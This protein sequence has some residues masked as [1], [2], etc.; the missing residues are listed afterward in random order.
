MKKIY[1]LLLAMSFL[2]FSC[3]DKVEG[4]DPGNSTTSDVELRIMQTASGTRAD[5]VPYPSAA[6][7]ED[8]KRI[9]TLDLIAFD[10]STKEFLYTRPAYPT[11]GNTYRA[12]LPSAY[13]I[14]D[15]ALLANCPASYITNLLASSQWAGSAKKWGDF[16]ELLID[17]D[18]QRLVN[19]DNFQ[20]LPMSRD[21]LGA[22]RLLTTGVADWGT[23]QL[24]RSVASVDV[25]MEKN[26]ATSKLELTKVHAYY[27]ASKGYI[28]GIEGV[29]AL[30]QLYKTPTDMETTLNTLVATRVGQTQ[31][32]DEPDIVT[33]DAVTSQIFMY[34]NNTVT[35]TSGNVNKCT[36]IIIEGYYN[37][38]VE[39]GTKKPSYY[40]IFLVDNGNFRPIT[41]NWKYLLKID[42]VYGP[43][44]ETITEA[45]E[46]SPINLNLEIIDWNLADV[47]VGVSGPYYVSVNKKEAIL[48][49]KAGSE[50]EILLTF[51]GEEADSFDINFETD[52]NGSQTGTGDVIA[53]NRFEVTL[54]TAS[55]TATL[56]VKALGAY[57]T[58]DTE[59]HDILILTYRNL[60]FE[61]AIHQLNQHEDDWNDGGNIPADL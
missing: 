46:S 52:D 21:T 47:E 5:V 40:P 31:T 54:T 25:V 35:N 27:A 56:K 11:A 34:D 41:R 3:N 43:G 7:T 16:Q 53:N 23:A 12:T 24:L 51:K 18:P 44:Y 45:A 19:S 33:Y 29:T 57:S 39:E 17:N 60:K 55:G 2:G 22:R 4:Y 15:V 20:P 6:G 36:R 8:E 10:T 49:R 26:A 48:S 37:Q 38:A 30:P 14:V 1:A 13:P 50:D 32:G 58:N 28:A 9:L 61:I 42:A 59:N